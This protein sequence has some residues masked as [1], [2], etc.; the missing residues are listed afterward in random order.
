MDT[1]QFIGVVNEQIDKNF[2]VNNELVEYVISELNQMNTQIT[3]EQAQHI[4]N[5]IEYASKSTSK[6]TVIAIANTLL[7][8]G[9]LKAD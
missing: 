4:V 1:K 8:L 7:E 3:Q 2:N 9:V 5:I 6:N